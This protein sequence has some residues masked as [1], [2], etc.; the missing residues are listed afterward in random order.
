MATGTSM[1]I[2]L[3]GF[4]ISASFI[5]YIF[6]R[7]ICARFQLSFTSPF[8]HSHMERGMNGLEAVMAA[9]FPV[10]EFGVEKDYQCTVCLTD[11]KKDDIL[12]ILPICTHTFHLVCIDQW[13]K[14]HST[15]PISRVSMG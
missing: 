1:I 12:R 14:Q 4:S 15:C 2:T 3:I 10:K 6:I 7:F 9:S 5:I 13:L 11:Y 8:S